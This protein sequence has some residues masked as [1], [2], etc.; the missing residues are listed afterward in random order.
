VYDLPPVKGDRSRVIQVLVNL[1]SNAYKYTP[2]GG[3]ISLLVERAKDSVKISVSDTGVGM[4]AEQIAKLG[5]KFWRADNDH[6]VDQPGTGLGLAITQNLIA[7]MGGELDVQSAPG[8][9]S[10]FT[11]TLPV[12]ADTTP[13]AQD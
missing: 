12:D 8:K 10:T 3:T 11:V 2:D 9:G 4:T 6:V 7:L 5:T 1:L 13:S